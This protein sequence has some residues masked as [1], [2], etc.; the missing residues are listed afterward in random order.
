MRGRQYGVSLIFVVIALVG[1]AVIFFA[2]T[3]LFRGSSGIASS[4]K[5]ATGFAAAS[6][7]LEQFAGTSGRLPCPAD[8]TAST[9]DAAPNTAATACTFPKGTVPWRTIGMRSE[10][11]LDA[12]GRKISYRVFSGTMGLTQDEGASMV[13]CDLDN[14]G[15]PT[16]SSLAPGG[17]CGLAHDH[18]VAQVLLLNKGL[19]A[20]DFGTIR[21]D[22]AYVLISHGPSGL[23]AHTS[24]GIPM[25]LPTS[26]AELANINT[27]DASGQ[28]IAKAAVTQGIAAD[29]ATYFDDIL[30][31]QSIPELVKRAN[32]SARNW[33]ESTNIVSNFTMDSATVG[34]AIL[35]TPTPDASTGRDDITFGSGSTQARVRG[36]DSGGNQDITFNT[37]GGASGLGITGN[38]NLLMTSTSSE[39]LR[40]DF[41]QSARK[42]AV[43]L[44]DFGTYVASGVTYTEEVE[45]RFRGGA[46]NVNVVKSGCRADGGVATFSIDPGT[47]FNRV[48]I[49]PQ[50]AVP[51]PFAITAMTVADFKTCTAGSEEC[52]SNLATASN[53][54]P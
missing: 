23:G 52:L 54:C 26:A 4:S 2:M 42:F 49:R 8:P 29:A 10:D 24:T 44:G 27:T 36:F 22:V 18:T 51:T 31:F 21:T 15:T 12:W 46:S 9:G 35:G 32:L 34:A 16:P 38:G 28:F 30:A 7:A 33:P 41:G 43:A 5:T 25:S 1:A 3:T 39:R 40:I 6:A 17:L 11:A 37:V 19:H 20:D 53:R 50:P 47:D 45:F 13:N 48:D 14:G